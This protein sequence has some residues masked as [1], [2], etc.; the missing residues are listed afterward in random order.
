MTANGEPHDLHLEYLKRRVKKPVNNRGGSFMSAFSSTFDVIGGDNHFNPNEPKA[1]YK[2]PH[3]RHYSLESPE[4][5]ESGYPWHYKK[6]LDY[7]KFVVPDLQAQDT[8]NSRYAGSTT[9]STYYEDG[10]QAR[11]TKNPQY[12][13]STTNSTYHED[14]WQARGMKSPSYAGSMTGSAYHDDG[15]STTSS[16]AGETESVYSL[17]EA[18]QENCNCSTHSNYKATVNASHRQEMPYNTSYR[19]GVS[20]TRRMVW[21]L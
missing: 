13:G 1:R 16:V 14:G 7:D 9:S 17:D 6:G 10:R 19:Q 3:T 11:G 15:W 20:H 8:K 12:A 21:K 18:F 5:Q 4:E 2:K